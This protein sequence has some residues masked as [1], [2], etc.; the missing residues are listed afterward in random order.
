MEQLVKQIAENHFHHANLENLVLTLKN[1]LDNTKGKKVYGYLKPEIKKT[2]DEIFRILS[3]DENISAL[4]DKW[5]ELERQK[6]KVYT[7]KEKEFPPLW[8]NKVFQPVRNMIIGQ[9][10]DMNFTSTIIEDYKMPDVD[11]NTEINPLEDHIFEPLIPEEYL[12]SENVIQN[13]YY[14]KWSDDY[15][16]AHK[17]IKEKSSEISDL[18][19]AERILLSESD[20]GNVLAMFELGKLYSMENLCLKNHLNII[21][22]PCRGFCKL[23]R[24]LKK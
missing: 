2:V 14:I 17:I 12:V 4:Y 24:K 19:T 5:C 20:T 8:E 13:K 15:K 9:V 16:F 18:K 7:Q 1:Q 23:S 11:Y 10:L 3:Q 21:K 22:K 6:Y